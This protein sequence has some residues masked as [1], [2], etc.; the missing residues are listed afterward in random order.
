MDSKQFTADA[1]GKLLPVQA[2]WGK[3]YAFIPN[4]LPPAWTFPEN[5]WPILADTRHQMGLLE[6]LGRTIP[7]PTILLRPLL[8]R[9]AIQSSALEGTFASAKE[10]LLFELD[11]KT[12]QS[13]SDP[14]ND[15]LEVD[16]YRKALQHGAESNLPIC[17]RLVCELHEVLMTNVRG[18]DRSPGKFR[19][20]QVGIGGARFIPPPPSKLDEPLES[21]EKYING[22]KSIY[23]PLVDCF[24]VHYQLETIHPFV[25]GNGRVGR[26]LLA[27]M[28]QH[29]CEFSKP[30]L[31]LSGFFEV[32][33]EA[34]VQYLFDVSARGNWTTWIEFCLQGTLSQARETITRCE[35]ILKLQD[36]Y[37]ARLRDID[38]ATRLNAI[39]DGIFDSPFVQITDLARKLNIHYQTAQADLEK[40]RLAK[41]LVELPDFRPK[42]FYAPEVFRVGYEQLD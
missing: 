31:Y 32:H 33:R 5:L 28:L 41:I 10:L 26:L 27:L 12:P 34:Y 6:G 37:M 42:T 29:K 20:V 1:P 23:D 30:W 9:E 8:R 2:D 36:E 18:R 35:R 19:T 11:P 24:L 13:E 15:R 25:D 7:N 14:I 21:L 39:V 3:D 17:W 16:N 38:G 40:L 4:P 22:D